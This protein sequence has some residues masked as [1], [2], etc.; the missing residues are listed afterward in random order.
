MPIVGEH[1]A[2]NAGSLF[3]SDLSAN[4]SLILFFASHG[5]PSWLNTN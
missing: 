2:V 3:T 4:R 5:L 1:T